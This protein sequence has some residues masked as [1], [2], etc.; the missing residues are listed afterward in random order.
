MG[1]RVHRSPVSLAKPVPVSREPDQ[2]FRADE[3]GFSLCAPRVVTPFSGSGAGRAG[4]SNGMQRASG[5][6]RRGPTW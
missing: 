1:N 3:R 5:W 6:V 2:D 4:L